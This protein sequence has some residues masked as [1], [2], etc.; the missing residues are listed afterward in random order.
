MNFSKVA[1]IVA[2]VFAAATA[3]ATVTAFKVNGVTVTK[4]EQEEVL[5]SIAKNGTK[6]NAAV[7]EYVRSQFIRQA[8]VEQAAKQAKIDRRA[9]IAKA[10]KST[11][12]AIL[13]QAYYADYIKKHPVSDETVKEAYEREKKNWGDREVKVRHILVK[14]KV[15]ADELM[16]QIKK[17]ADFAKLARENSLDSEDNKKEGGLID[18]TSPRVFDRDF[19]IGLTNLA[20]GELCRAPVQ[21]RLGWH[22]IKLEGERPAKRWENF[23]D[24][25][26]QLRQLLEQDSF[27]KH[28]QSLANKAKVVN[29]K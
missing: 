20:P 27:A 18:W 7:E 3:S 1:V 14:D 2:S 23:A 6:V 13:S 25:E 8:V 16:S 12:T 9:D 29:I 11:Q 26:K 22:I 28:V 19:A 21:S 10:I 17:G 4:A 5:A 24:N 15:K